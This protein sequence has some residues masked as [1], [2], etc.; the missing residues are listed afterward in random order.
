MI[1][2][3]LQKILGRKKTGPPQK[4][5]PPQKI[6]AS[7]QENQEVTYVHEPLGIRLMTSGHSREVMAP[8][9]ARHYAGRFLTVHATHFVRAEAGIRLD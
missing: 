4:T 9:G 1:K 8:L 5:C 7:H 2:N 3:W 6:G